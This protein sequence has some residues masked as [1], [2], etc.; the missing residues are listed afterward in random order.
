MDAKTGVKRVSGPYFALQT[1]CAFL[2]FRKMTRRL[3]M[4]SKIAFFSFVIVSFCFIF[5]G[6]FDIAPFCMANKRKKW[7]FF[8]HF[9]RFRAIVSQDAGF[10]AVY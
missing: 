5:D 2:D 1:Y 10:R 9:G 7:S 3:S 6:F 4:Q 8:D